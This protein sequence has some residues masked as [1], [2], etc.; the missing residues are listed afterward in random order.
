MCWNVMSSMT[1]MKVILEQCEM[2]A[3]V[4]LTSC[5]YACFLHVEC[6][7]GTSL[8]SFMFTPDGISEIYTVQTGNHPEKVRPLNEFEVVLEFSR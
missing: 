1:L 6:K 8:P 3:W 7:D 2:N 4:R 5:Q